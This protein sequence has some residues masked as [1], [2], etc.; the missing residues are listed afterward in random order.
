MAGQISRENGMLGGRPKG[1][2]T[3]TTE[4]VRQRIAVEIDPFVSR[5]VKVLIKKGLKGDMRAIKELF[6]RAYGKSPSAPETPRFSPFN[7]SFNKEDREKYM[8]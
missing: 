4:A 5:F 8:C 3:L 2:N 6:D 1:N 7:F